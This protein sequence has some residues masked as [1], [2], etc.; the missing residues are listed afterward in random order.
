VTFLPPPARVLRPDAPLREITPWGTKRALL[1][2]HGVASIVR[3]RF[4]RAL[5]DLA[6]EEFVRRV[7]PRGIR[8]AE[9]VVGY[10]FRFGAGASGTVATL[11][12]L[13][14]ERGFR[15]RRLGAVLHRG[16]PISSTRI[17]RAIAS[18]RLAEAEAMLGR[19]FGL[20][21]RVVSGRGLGARLFVA[22][23]NVRPPGTQLLPPP[24]VYLA[25]ARRGRR[26]WGAV[27]HVGASPTLGGETG[28]PV[29]VHLLGFRG[30]LRGCLL[31]LELLEKRRES[32]RFRSP[33]A[34]REAI[35]RDVR[36]AER[37]F[38]RGGQNRVA[39]GSPRW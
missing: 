5:A 32:R 22:T 35:L 28:A 25:R 33:A 16:E 6:P 38:V 7:L 9:V 39:P 27:A 15:V 13:G 20:V 34:L 10:D 37:A 24:G 11:R 8:L 18:G 36:W 19:P 26:A 3:L 21:G 29:E 4:S 23:A 30:S 2:R 1:A 14:R 17:R 31:S 12:R